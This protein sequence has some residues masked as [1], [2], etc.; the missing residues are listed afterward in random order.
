MSAVRE[1]TPVGAAGS[2][3]HLRVSLRAQGV[4]TQVKKL[5]ECQVLPKPTEG[6]NLSL[7][8]MVCVS[9]PCIFQ[10]TFSKL[11]CVSGQLFRFLV[12]A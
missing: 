5:L 3:N 7:F 10:S 8:D 11:G 9:V 6:F 1:M 2:G 4:H 12:G